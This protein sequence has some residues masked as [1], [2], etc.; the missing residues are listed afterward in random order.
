M[1]AA[2]IPVLLGRVL[3]IFAGKVPVR[4]LYQRAFLV[5]LVCGA[6]GYAVGFLVK[7]THGKNVFGHEEKA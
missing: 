3:D 5:C 7:E 6:L 4:Q 2:F 1:G